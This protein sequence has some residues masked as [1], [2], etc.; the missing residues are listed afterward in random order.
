M[1]NN[2]GIG[3]VAKVQ[4]FPLDK[5]NATIAIKLGNAFCTFRLALPAMLQT[6]MGSEG[7]DAA[8]TVRRPMGWL[9][10]AQKSACVVA[11][12]GLLGLTG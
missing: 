10:S 3:P 9:G 5:R 12:H 8:S 4:D 1:V 11:K 7:R 6:E 2:A